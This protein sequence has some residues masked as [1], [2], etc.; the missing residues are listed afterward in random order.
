M[1][2]KVNRKGTATVTPDLLLEIE[3]RGSG[4]TR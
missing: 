1:T 3:G 4:K 2:V